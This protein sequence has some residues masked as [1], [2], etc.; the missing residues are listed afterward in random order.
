MTESTSVVKA[1]VL[2]GFENANA[3]SVSRLLSNQHQH[4]EQPL[5]V[6]T[7]IAGSIS[8]DESKFQAGVEADNAEQTQ[9]QKHPQGEP[10]HPIK[11]KILVGV[12]VIS[13]ESYLMLNHTWGQPNNTYTEDYAEGEGA[14]KEQQRLPFT[15][16]FVTF[17]SKQEMIQ[18][19]PHG[20]L[21]NANATTLTS[22]R[23][24]EVE[25]YDWYLRCPSTAYVHVP[26]L[27][28]HLESISMTSITTQQQDKEQAQEQPVLYLGWE[29]GEPQYADIYDH[30]QVW[31]RATAQVLVE[32]CRDIGVG[33]GSS[34][35]ALLDHCLATHGVPLTLLPPLPASAQTL[36]EFGG[37][38]CADQNNQKQQMQ[39]LASASTPTSSLS[40]SS[41]WMFPDALPGR[42]PRTLGM[43][44]SKEY[45]HAF[46]SIVGRGA[47]AGASSDADASALALTAVDCTCTLS[48]AHQLL[49]ICGDFIEEDACRRDLQE[50][51]MGSEEAVA[52]LFLPPCALADINVGVGNNH[53]VNAISVVDVPTSGLPAY[54]I[55]LDRPAA[56]HRLHTYMPSSSVFPRAHQHVVDGIRLKD[57]GSEGYRQSMTKALMEGLASP[58]NHAVIAVFDDDF[59]VS[60]EFKATWKT[61]TQTWTWKT[62]NTETGT[63]SSSSSSS[64]SNTCYHDTLSQGGVLLLGTSVWSDTWFDF[65]DHHPDEPYLHDSDSWSH[66]NSSGNGTTDAMCYDVHAYVKGSYATLFSRHAAEQALIWLEL[67]RPYSRPFDWIWGDFVELG[68]LPV[69]AVL[70]N[71]FVA[72]VE[73]TSVVNPNRDAFRAAFG[74]HKA[75]RWGPVDAYVPPSGVY[76]QSANST[77]GTGTN[78]ADH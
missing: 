68:I 46:S 45:P 44:L 10:P 65:L 11:M 19:Q 78:M 70:H 16:D 76:G 12:G 54:V 47:G 26:Q 22:T 37:G 38:R 3:V 77:D 36:L 31:N 61:L 73:H 39:I 53:K 43:V 57:N 72:D 63:G 59:R 6:R 62:S 23:D 8:T 69:R 32:K 49:T 58:S 21:E 13:Q 25:D 35:S 64:S 42:A 30:C 28:A 27:Y 60:K 67:T 34:N 55:S 18:R 50:Q 29:G 24:A 2:D 41:S 17:I 9:Q 7:R 40:S 74:R 66:S 48:P 33:K 15:I 52:K 71:M 4:Q 20:A 75:Q 51:G 5:N 14:N 1:K 56:E